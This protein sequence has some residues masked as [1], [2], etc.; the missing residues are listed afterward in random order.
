M[1]AAHIALQL[2]GLAATLE[3]VLGIY[4]A[5]ATTCTGERTR[6][7]E[8]RLAK[9]LKLAKANYDPNF[10][11][12][13]NVPLKPAIADQA[14]APVFNDGDLTEIT[15]WLK[16]QALDLD[17]LS[18]AINGARPREPDLRHVALILAIYRR[19][20]EAN[21]HGKISQASVTRSAAANNIHLNGKAISAYRHELIRIGALVCV[22]SAYLHGVRA[23]CFAA[24]PN[25]PTTAWMAA[26]VQWAGHS[27]IG[28][29]SI[30]CTSLL[31]PACAPES[32]EP[33]DHV[34]TQWAIEHEEEMEASK[35]W[36]GVAEAPAPEGW[37]GSKDI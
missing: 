13:G 21:N 17:S 7:R 23:Q 29:K 36:L 32:E 2:H 28:H 4:E 15:T 8:R 10:T 22:D 24:G 35:D 34:W 11:Q 26:M 19:Y 6:K 25:L 14:E 20:C 31:P 16:G 1:A 3:D 33:P 30:R 27:G 12:R 9:A 37:D 5:F 18:T